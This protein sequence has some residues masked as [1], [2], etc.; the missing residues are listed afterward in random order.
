MVSSLLGRPLIF[1]EVL[2]FGACKYFTPERRGFP[3]LRGEPGEQ[4]KEEK[5]KKR[6]KTARLAAR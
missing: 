4:K 1:E 6:K 2:L 3:L 5:K